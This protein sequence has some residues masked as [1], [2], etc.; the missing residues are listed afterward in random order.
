MID[1]LIIGLVLLAVALIGVPILLWV[2]R[3]AAKIIRILFEVAITLF[4]IGGIVLLII[5]LV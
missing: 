3:G 2:L 4:L 5:Y 1:Y